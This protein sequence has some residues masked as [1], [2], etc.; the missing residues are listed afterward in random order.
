ML[1]PFEILT[2]PI[3]LA[4]MAMYVTL[5]IWETWFPRLRHLPRITNATFR[6]ILGFVVFLLL[7]TYLPLITDEYLS[8]YQL[9]DL[10]ELPLGAQVITGL[11]VYQLLLYM[12]H[13]TMHRSEVLWR[14]FHQM[15]HSSE[16]L[17][18]PSTFYFSPMDIAGLTFLG[19]IVFA[20]IMGVDP[21]AATVIILFLSFLSIFQHANIRTPVWLG[22]IIQRPEQ[23]AVHHSRGVH[24]HNYSDFPI[25]DLIFG[26]FKNP[27]D[28][29]GE[30]GFYLGAST[31]VLDML[32]F[33]DVSKERPSSDDQEAEDPYHWKTA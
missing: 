19:S 14:V 7:S 26:T 25:Y 16:K 21:R 18:I 22:Y 4:V 29:Q 6:G 13:R 32:Y 27:A 2:D 1:T 23:H 11:L 9:F 30:Y 12:W 3:S 15:H 28:H 31:R 8:S 17:D 10:S 5:Y 24:A 33:R 20:L